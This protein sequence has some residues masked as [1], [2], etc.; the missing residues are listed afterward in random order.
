MG[1]RNLEGG[2]TEVSAAV[3]VAKMFLNART[4][5]QRVAHS[6]EKLP[7]KVNTKTSRA[8]RKK[9]VD[10]TSFGSPKNAP[11]NFQ[12]LSLEAELGNTYEVRKVRVLRALIAGVNPDR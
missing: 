7:C 9:L 6:D 12:R 11:Q 3:L 1:G 8:L 10:Q 5:C 2:T 4:A